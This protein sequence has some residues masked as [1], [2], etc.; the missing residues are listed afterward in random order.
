[1]FYNKDSM[2]LPSDANPRVGC[3]ERKLLNYH[4]GFAVTPFCQDNKNS[5]RTLMMIVLG[6]VGL[7]WGGVLYNMQQA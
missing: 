3:N 2:L 5:L 7:V 1:M 4:N 6:E